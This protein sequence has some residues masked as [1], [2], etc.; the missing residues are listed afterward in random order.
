M[1][2]GG[3]VKRQEEDG[4]GAGGG[5]QLA[6]MRLWAGL[7]PWLP[8]CGCHQSGQIKKGL[9]LQGDVGLGISQQ[10]GPDVN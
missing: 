5:W 6:N 10:Q 3:E 7:W 9:Q 4:G 1:G 2:K 8:L